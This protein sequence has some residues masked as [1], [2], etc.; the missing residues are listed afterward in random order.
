MGCD[1]I[2]VDCGS[3]TVFGFDVA[4]VPG[5]VVLCGVADVPV[6]VPVIVLVIMQLIVWLACTV[7]LQPLENVG[8][9]K[10]NC[11]GKTFSDTLMVFPDCIQN[12][13]GVEAAVKVKVLGEPLFV[14]V[15]VNGIVFAVPEAI[16]LGSEIALVTVTIPL[17]EGLQIKPGRVAYWG[18]AWLFPDVTSPDWEGLADVVEEPLGTT[19]FCLLIDGDD[20][21]IP[22]EEF[23]AASF[24]SAYKIELPDDEKM[25]ATKK[26]NT[27]VTKILFSI[28]LILLSD[29]DAIK[30]RFL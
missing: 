21:V 17:F 28:S 3:G 25:L 18:V 9:E 19:M 22:P 7:V 23:V 15:I 11:V 10:V 26:V 2:K 8:E 5:I 14:K 13:C 12:A 1:V 4:G 29:L 30:K 16:L 20:D 6:P 24:A 27:S